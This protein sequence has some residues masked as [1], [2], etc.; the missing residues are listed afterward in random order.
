MPAMP[1]MP[2]MFTGARIRKIK[3]KDYESV[4]A[5]TNTF[6]PYTEMNLA[7]VQER[8]ARGARYFVAEINERVV[9]FVDLKISGARA[10]IYGIAVDGRHEGK[11][12]GSALLNRALSFARRNG[13][14]KIWIKVKS[15]NLPAINLYR[16]FGFALKKITPGVREAIYVMCKEIE[17]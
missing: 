4:V 7:K 6:F 9:G 8:I 17:T 10:V 11:G 12:I 16:N 5:L 2:D 1:R 14:R 3:R 15:S 13:A